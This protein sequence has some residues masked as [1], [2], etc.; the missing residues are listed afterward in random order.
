[1]KKDNKLVAITHGDIN[2]IG[3]EVIM[4]TLMDN[5]ILE[6]ITP[7]VY[8]S[9]KVAAY[10]R[11]ALNISNFSFNTVR[12]IEEAAGSKANIINCVDDNI[13]VELGKSTTMAGE[14]SVR[15]IETAMNDLLKEKVDI[16]VTAPINKHNIWSD[17][18]PFAG[19]TEYLKAKAGVDDVLMIMVSENMKV[20]LVTGHLALKDVPAA[21]TPELIMSKLRIMNNSLTVDFGV[22]KPRIAVLSVNPHAGDGGILGTEEEEVVIPALRQAGDEGILVF[23]PYPSDG[24]FGAGS[25]RKFDGIL[26]MYHDQGL[27]PFKAMSFDTGV[28][29]TAG[30]PFVRTSPNHGTAYELAG[31]GEA[32]ENSFRQALYLALDI[33]RNREFHATITSDPLSSQVVDT[34]SGS[35]DLPEDENEGDNL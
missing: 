7:V 20:G 13:R 15:S 19:H 8:G 28:N 10:H 29:Y 34:Q 2:G 5:R 33:H 26:A 18:F 32:S 3:Y 23:G 1:M 6:G 30:L 11:K 9:P 31:L 24:F 21:I 16:L 17:N 25:F 27:T 22:R 35:E 4:K 12:S 14:A